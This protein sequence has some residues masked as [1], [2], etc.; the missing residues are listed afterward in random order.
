VTHI[1]DHLADG[2]TEML[3]GAR[4][5]FTSKEAAEADAALRRE[6]AGL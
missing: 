3:D 2:R 6:L 1:Q 4:W 5:S